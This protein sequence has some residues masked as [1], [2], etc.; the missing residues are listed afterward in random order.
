MTSS[1]PIL[2][3]ISAAADYSIQSEKKT[4]V[5]SILDFLNYSISRVFSILVHYSTSIENRC[6]STFVPTALKF[7]ISM[8]RITI[9]QTKNMPS[10]TWASDGLWNAMRVAQTA[11]SAARSFWRRHTPDYTLSN[12]L[13]CKWVA[14]IRN[15]SSQQRK[16]LFLQCTA[17]SFVSK[18]K[19]I[20]V[21]RTVWCFRFAILCLS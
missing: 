5:S 12:F 9:M 18:R 17:S 14:P 4:L 11:V 16:L 6:T 15:F 21:V 8:Y 3:I 1:N 19:L 13:F 2:K 20:S 7:A 10:Q